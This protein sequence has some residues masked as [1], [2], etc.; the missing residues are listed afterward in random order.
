[1]NFLSWFRNSV[2]GNNRPGEAHMTWAKS[3]LGHTV[4]RTGVFFKRHL[5]VWPILAVVLLSVI[6]LVVR[7]A[8]EKTMRDGLQSQLQTVLD[9][10]SA[11]LNSW[12]GVQ[13]SNVESLANNV[14]IRQTVY[15]LLEAAADESGKTKD[16]IP[17][18]Q[19]KLNKSLGPAITA[20]RYAG[21]IVWDKQ[22][23]IVAAARPEMLGQ[24]DLPEYASFVNRALDGA[25]VVSAPFSSMVLM[26]DENG[27][28]RTGNPT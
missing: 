28:M 27:R 14:D 23:R 20:H 1:M 21:Y 11:M 22:K 25:T 26:K 8:I 18:L 19:A 17:A 5:W 13:K 15:P 6:G 12:Y 7:H 24:R 10:E 2:H 9:L 16:S 4:S 3:S